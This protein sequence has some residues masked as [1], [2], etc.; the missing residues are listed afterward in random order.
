MPDE[1]PEPI[2][3]AAIDPARNIRRR[4]AVRVDRNLFGDLEVETSW[5]RIGTRGQSK[6]IRFANLVSATVYV[7]QVMKR[8]STAHR[9]L[10]V[11]Y[12]LWG[13]VPDGSDRQTGP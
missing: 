6:V 11:P 8:R 3:L 13:E 9:R 12:L 2:F 4:Y 1:L 10:G 5:G 7:K